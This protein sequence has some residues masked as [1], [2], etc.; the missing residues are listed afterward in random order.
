MAIKKPLRQL[1]WL[2]DLFEDPYLHAYSEGNLEAWMSTAGFGAVRTQIV[3]LI[4]QLT[5]GVKPIAESEF[6]FPLGGEG[7]M[8]V[9]F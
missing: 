3:W 1:P 2:V 6:D 5:H 8:A 7:V 9:S 4:H